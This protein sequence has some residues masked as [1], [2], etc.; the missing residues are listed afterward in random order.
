MRTKKADADAGSRM[1]ML[2][3]L[4]SPQFLPTIREFV[5]PMSF[6]IASD[7]ARQP[8]GRNDYRESEL[9]RRDEVFLTRDQKRSDLRAFS[10][11]K[12]LRLVAC[13]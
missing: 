9:V 1:H 8:K 13:S 6:L 7:A 4:E 11:K 3:W 10:K 5:A 12:A 2:D